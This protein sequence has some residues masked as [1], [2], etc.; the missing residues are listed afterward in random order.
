VNIDLTGVNIALSPV[1]H[2]A[3]TLSD[4]FEVIA[5]YSCR[6]RTAAGLSQVHYPS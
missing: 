5:R 2:I 1:V 6:P 4:K 3:S